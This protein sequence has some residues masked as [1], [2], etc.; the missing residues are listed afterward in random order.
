MKN[1]IFVEDFD[2]LEDHK[3]YIFWGFGTRNSYY[4]KKCLNNILFI[5]DNNEKL[6]K[7]KYFDFDVKS[8]I[9]IKKYLNPICIIGSYSESILEQIT[10]MNL[11]NDIYIV[12]STSSEPIYKLNED[13]FMSDIS[14]KKKKEIFKKNIRMVEIEPHSFC[15]RV[16]WFCPNSFI[17]RRSETKYMDRSILLK[18]LKDLKSIKYNEL[19]SFTR[20]SEPF[21]NEIFF[22]TLKLV[23]EYLPNAILHANT[24]SDYLNNETLH[25]AYD[26]GLRSLNIQI[27]LGEE[28]NFCLDYVQKKAGKIIKKISDVAIKLESNTDSWISY[29]CSYKD[30]NIKMYARDFHD[31]GINRGGLNVSSGEKKRY[32][33]CS[34]PFNYVY[35]DYNGSIVPCCNM[36][37]D[38]KEDEN[39]YIVGKLTSL[40][41]IFDLYFN[42]K[43]IDFRK[44]IFNYDVEKKPNL[45]KTCFMAQINDTV[46][47]RIS[48]SKINGRV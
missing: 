27:Y 22:E 19:I 29:Q 1:V 18:L 44:M 38:L 28:E 10:N 46:L 21:G 37:S 3:K 39:N 4:L 11:P 24:N 26:S 5:V 32:T 33:P 2:F 20:Y 12:V 8:P 41:S 15:N 13:F 43:M 45:C 14:L 16:C 48:L 25:K 7:K 30:M 31:S 9:E 35:V 34:M 47:N 17:D 6:W 23:K 42:N 40:N 36:R